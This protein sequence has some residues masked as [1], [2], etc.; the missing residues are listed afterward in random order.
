MTVSVVQ[1]GVMGMG[2]H[3]RLVLV[4]VGMRLRAVPGPIVLVLVVL[5]VP[6]CMGMDQP[7]VAVEMRVA[8]RDVQPDPNRH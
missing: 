7:F 2:V 5:I 3:N 4:V 6:V 1:I 8:L